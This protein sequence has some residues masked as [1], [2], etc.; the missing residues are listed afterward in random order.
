MSGFNMI[1]K[2][3]VLEMANTGLEYELFVKKIFYAINNVNSN[4]EF[5]NIDIKHDVKITD[6]NGI[7]RQFDIYWEYEM[8]G[9]IYKTI[10]ECRDYNSNISVEKVDSLIGKI[11][12]I[13]SINKAIFATKS[14]YQS[15]AKTKA[16]NNDIE[17]LI[18]REQNNSDR[19]DSNG[20]AYITQICIQQSLIPPAKI[21]NFDC[22]VDGQ[23]INENK[24]QDISMVLQGYNNMISIQDVENNN[25]YSLYDLANSIRFKH[26]E[27][28]GVFEKK[29]I[30]KNA[31]LFNE[32]KNI[33]VKIIGY[34]VQY[35]INK[36][37]NTPLIEIDFKD[38]ILGVVE[39][40]KKGN[41]KLISKDQKV[42][43]RE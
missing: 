35:E 42:L 14:G 27:S 37:Y 4:D 18:V 31:F 12:D 25:N 43:D 13:P 5:K 38:E 32:E 26:K 40:L 17:L 20:N 29:E 9:F 21:L 36:P 23:W 15:G 34:K 3:W 39:Y 1:V 2:T 22:T 33:K 6:N 24:L 8:C 7:E 16:L 19:F 28:Y 41:K 11:K 10:V 30:F